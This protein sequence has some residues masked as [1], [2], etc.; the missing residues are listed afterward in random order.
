MNQQETWDA[1]NEKEEKYG[2]DLQ[3][4]QIFSHGV[5]CLITQVLI[6]HTHGDYLLMQRDYSKKVAPKKYEA[7]GGS[8]LKG[9]TSYQAAIREAKEETGLDIY[10]LQLVNKLIDKNP[11]VG[12]K[13]AIYHYYVAKTNDDKTS[14][15]LQDGETMGYKWL[16]KK[17]FLD[18]FQSDNCIL[19]QLNGFEP[20]L[21]SIRDNKVCI[22]IGI[23]KDK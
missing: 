15:V 12:I 4:G 1:Y 14:V 8:V 23:N 7:S 3:K 10:D 18:F 16:T 22:K 19:F 21:K 6:Q 11:A 13:P 20:Y 5:F 17:E 2:F 9:E